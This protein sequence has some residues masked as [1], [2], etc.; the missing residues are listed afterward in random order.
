MQ[1]KLKIITPFEAKRFSNLYLKIE[2]PSR[3]K[4]FISQVTV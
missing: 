1:L 3:S 4:H 2:I